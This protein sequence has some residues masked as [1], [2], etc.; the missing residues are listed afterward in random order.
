MV[1]E[2]IGVSKNELCTMVN[3]EFT[4][5]Y[6][7]KYRQFEQH[8]STKK[9]NGCASNNRNLN[10]RVTSMMDSFMGLL[11]SEGAN[12]DDGQGDEEPFAN[13]L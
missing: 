9:D 2:K 8:T 10:N 7:L 11:D 3:H 12:E 13:E 6:F 1:M 4:V 5:Y